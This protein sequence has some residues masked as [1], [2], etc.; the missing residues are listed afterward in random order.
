LRLLRA[1]C[2]WNEQ[3][4]KHNEDRSQSSH[5]ETTNEDALD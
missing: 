1:N 2:S 4:D 5:C 3:R